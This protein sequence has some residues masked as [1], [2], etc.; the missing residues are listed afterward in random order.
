MTSDLGLASEFLVTQGEDALFCY[1]PL[2][3]TCLFRY[4]C[5]NKGLEFVL[6]AGTISCFFSVS[7]KS[8]SSEKN[9][10]VYRV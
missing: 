8:Q 2:F 6:E 1:S 5:E 4:A 3:A 7:F 10:L 9:I